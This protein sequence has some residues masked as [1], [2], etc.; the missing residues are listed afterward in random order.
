LITPETKISIIK[1]DTKEKVIKELTES[2]ELQNENQVCVVLDNV[3]LK[4]ALEE[5][6]VSK[7]FLKTVKNCE[8]A[9]CCRV[10][11]LQK[12]KVVKTVQNKF[13]KVCLAVGDGNNDV[14]MIQEAKIGVG[15]QGREGS[16]AASASDYSL[17]R[18]KHLKRLIAVHGRYSLIR[19]SYFIQ[20]SFYKNMLISFSL[21]SFTSVCLLSGTSV[22]NSWFL[23]CYNLVFTVFPPIC[24]ATFERD[25]DEKTLE[26]N[27]ILFS[28]LKK[29][30][31]FNVWT[32]GVWI[33]QALYHG[34]VISAV[35]FVSISE[36]SQFENMYSDG[37]FEAS[38]YIGS[39]ALVN[40]YFY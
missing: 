32:F 5:K 11:P 40:F 10:S 19:N 7:L 20:Y 38:F 24:V 25:V 14:S 1:G 2:L 18:F 12:A 29:N 17:P 31:V 37:L 27:P 34:L 36:S 13:K 15:I 26:N 16:Q 28:T 23:T 22:Y 6:E 8:S 4:V 9:L 30:Y 21:I 35:T 3:S 39:F 33:L